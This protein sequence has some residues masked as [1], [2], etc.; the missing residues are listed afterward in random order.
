MKRGA[1]WAAWTFAIV[2]AVAGLLTW[3]GIIPNNPEACGEA[4]TPIAVLVFLLV[5]ASNSAKR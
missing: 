5:W 1:I 4:A 2:F 3:A